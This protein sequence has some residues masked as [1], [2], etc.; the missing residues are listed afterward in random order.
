M[1]RAPG[2]DTAPPV[3]A[4]VFVVIALVVVGSIV[5]GAYFKKK[6]REGLAVA[7]KQLGFQYSPSDPF[8]LL[9]LPF[10]L[11]TRGDGRGV[12]NVMW[13]T[14]QGMD[15]KEFDYW[16]YT[17]S[18]DSKGHTSRS[19]SHFSCAVTEIP[20]TCGGLTITREGFF[21]RLADHLGFHDIQF[22]SEEFNRQFQVKCK[23]QK[24]ANDM[25]DSRMMQWLMGLDEGRS[26]E[27]TG[28]YVMC[29][30]RRARPLEITPLLGTLKGFQQHIPRVVWDLYGTGGSGKV[31][32]TG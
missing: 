8:G 12:E 32:F 27:L 13:G 7:A 30:S 15:L 19:Y 23:N 29:Y 11:L 2:G 24:F 16:Y 6:R 22:E 17:E 21:G 25:I 20:A 5:A 14:W 4:L 9:G 1:R 31:T 18:T 10:S 28:P 26:F 3:E